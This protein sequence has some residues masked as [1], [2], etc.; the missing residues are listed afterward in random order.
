M[1]LQTRSGERGGER[2]GERQAK[3]STC[4]FC[5]EHSILVESQ[6]EQAS[7]PEWVFP[8]THEQAELWPWDRACGRW[9]PHENLQASR[10]KWAEH[11]LWIW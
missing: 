9:G 11:G 3:E 2:G 8:G 4:V 7:F 5:Y 1:W 6:L 10:E